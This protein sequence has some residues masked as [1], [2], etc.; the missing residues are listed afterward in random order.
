MKQT[1]KGEKMNITNKKTTLNEF[2]S[3]VN[4]SV[5]RIISTPNYFRGDFQ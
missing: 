4:Q 1:K 5:D 2:L 3:C